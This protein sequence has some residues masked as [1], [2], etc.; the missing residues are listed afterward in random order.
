MPLFLV[1][2]QNLNPFRGAAA[3]NVHE[4]H[5]PGGLANPS[6]RDTRTGHDSLN[7]NHQHRHAS[8]IVGTLARELLM[9]KYFVAV[10]NSRLQNTSPYSFSFFAP[11]RRTTRSRTPAR[12]N[13]SAGGK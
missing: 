3:A 7:A 2:P 8:L 10:G 1:S 12:E 13:K 6:A 4:T 11:P 9:D 5:D